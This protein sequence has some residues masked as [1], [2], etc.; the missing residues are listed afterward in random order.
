MWPKNKKQR[1]DWQ[2]RQEDY[3]QDIQSLREERDELKAWC[4]ELES[5]QRQQG[6]NQQVFRY[7]ARAVDDLKRVKGSSAPSAKL[8]DEK[9]QK[10]LSHHLE[11]T[12]RRKDLLEY[13]DG[14]TESYRQVNNSQEHVQQIQSHASKMINSCADLDGL[15]ERLRLLSL[16]I[17]IE[18]SHTD[19]QQLSDSITGSLRE[20]SDSSRKVCAEIT[21]L[22]QR[23]ESDSKLAESYFTTVTEGFIGFSRAISPLLTAADQ[24]SELIL[25]L[26][27][28]T[29]QWIVDS[30]Q[31]SM[32]VEHILWKFD[33]YSVLLGFVEGPIQGH[34]ELANWEG[35]L[36][37]RGAVSVRIEEALVKVGQLG[38]DIQGHHLA[39][40]TDA[41]LADLRALDELS[42][43]LFQCFDEQRQEILTNG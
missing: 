16:N 38:K 8:W 28:I 4:E 34:G 25:E 32:Q 13:V 7:W 26:D 41:V 12:D 40:D 9:N 22:N 23:I 6:F 29:R 14:F 27:F 31:Q 37:A 19:K 5:R 15:T 3:E 33:I 10:F 20:M 24:S 35:M 43:L 36:Q 18:S 1:D 39:V 17:A 11:Y 30:F 21:E 2:G 42:E